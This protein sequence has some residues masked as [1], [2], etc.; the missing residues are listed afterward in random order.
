MTGE[1]MNAITGMELTQSDIFSL[2]QA[3]GVSMEGSKRTS[4]SGGAQSTADLASP[5]GGMVG[6]V[7]PEAAMAGG[8]PPDGVSGD[9]GAV[10]PN[11]CTDQSQV[12]GAGTG[13]EGS[14]G[15]PNV[16]VDALIQYLE[17]IAGI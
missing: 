1:Q 17:Q 10:G 12:A 9:L 11:V 13:V 16:L 2:V 14:A 5:D 8:A 6:G 7:P 15:V 4:S 3:Q